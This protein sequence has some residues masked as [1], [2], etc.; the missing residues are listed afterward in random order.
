[1]FQSCARIAAIAV[2][3]LMG[4][5]SASADSASAEKIFCGDLRKALQ[6]QPNFAS[7][8]TK[9]CRGKPNCSFSRLTIEDP[10]YTDMLT[11][12]SVERGAYGHSLVCVMGHDDM[13]AHSIRSDVRQDIIFCSYFFSRTKF[14]ASFFGPNTFQGECIYVADRAWGRLWIHEQFFKKTWLWFVRLEIFG[15][16][17][18]PNGI[19]PPPSPATVTPP[20][21]CAPTIGR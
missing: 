19:T 21:P 17:S 2:V 12:C 11:G 8:I 5:N 1:V 16:P 18:N 20:P 14:Q 3:S 4:A 6:Y 13:G 15:P 9:Q 7:L 10:R